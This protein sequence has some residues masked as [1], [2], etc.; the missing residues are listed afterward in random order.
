MISGSASASGG[1]LRVQSCM[2]LGIPKLDGDL[3]WLSAT[4]YTR[5]IAGNW[6]RLILCCQQISAQP[7]YLEDS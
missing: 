3:L 7:G 1:T 5:C 2:M 4:A 6:K